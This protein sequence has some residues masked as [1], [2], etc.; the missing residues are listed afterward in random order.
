[1]NGKA[2]LRLFDP[3]GAIALTYFAVLDHWFGL[4]AAC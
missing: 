1:M 4:L 3:R 2:F